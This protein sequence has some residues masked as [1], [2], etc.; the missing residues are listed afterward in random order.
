[1]LPAII[2]HNATFKAVCKI[3]CKMSKLAT[4]SARMSA[5]KVIFRL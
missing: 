4:L 5:Q 1:M 2:L 3:H